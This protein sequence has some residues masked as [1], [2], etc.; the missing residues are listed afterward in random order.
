M[1]SQIFLTILLSLSL[2]SCDGGTSSN[3][4][5]RRVENVSQSTEPSQDGSTVTQVNAADIQIDPDGNPTILNDP[6]R[7]VEAVRNADGTIT[8]TNGD[9]SV[10]IF[11]PED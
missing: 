1:I 8:V 3:T 7:E 6:T 11:N 4:E 9:G 10:V 5:T 2:I